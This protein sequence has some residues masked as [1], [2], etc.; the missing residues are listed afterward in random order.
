[1]TFSEP[2]WPQTRPSGLSMKFKRHHGCTQ[3]AEWEGV[4]HATEKNIRQCNRKQACNTD[5]HET[6]SIEAGRRHE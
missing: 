2:E 1:M 5:L 4:K 6:V 3:C